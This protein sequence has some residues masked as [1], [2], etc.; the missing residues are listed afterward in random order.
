MKKIQKLLAIVF[1][2]LLAFS[3]VI[4]PQAEEAAEP[5]EP[6]K[7]TKAIQLAI[8]F[9]DGTE[10]TKKAAYVRLWDSNMMYAPATLGDFA[11]NVVIAGSDWYVQY[12][13]AMSDAITGFGGL[14]VAGGSNWQYVGAPTADRTDGIGQW[15]TAKMSLE[16]MG[17]SSSWSQKIADFLLCFET[18]QAVD[19]NRTYYMYYKNMTIRNGAGEVVYRLFGDDITSKQMSTLYSVWSESNA[20][21]TPSV[22]TD[23]YTDSLYADK[24]IQMKIDFTNGDAG[25]N[26]AVQLQLYGECL[27]NAP[28][29]LG[30]R[31]ETDTENCFIQGSDWSLKYDYAISDS[32]VGLGNIQVQAR[33]NWNL[34]GDP[35]ADHTAGTGVWQTEIASLEGLGCTSSW[36]QGLYTVALSAVT[37]AAVDTTKSYYAW[38]KNIEIID[39]N[40]NV[41]YTL[42]DDTVNNREISATWQTWGAP[43]NCEVELSVVRDPFDT[44]RAVANTTKALEAKIRFTNGE[45][46]V[47]K[48]ATQALW[49]TYLVGL[50]DKIEANRYCYRTNLTNV[51]M[52]IEGM[53]WTL[54]YEYMIS[55]PIVGLGTAMTQDGDVWAVCGD[56][57][58]DHTDGVGVWQKEVVSLYD[59][60]A[61]PT[62]V[63]PLYAVGLTVN[64]TAA[65]DTDRDYYAYYKNIVIKDGNGDIQYVLFHDD[66][67]Q[68]ELYVLYWNN[69]SNATMDL[70]V[71]NLPNKITKA[72]TENGSFN[73]RALASNEAVVEV[74]AKPAYGYKVGSVTVGDL[75]VTKAAR[76][77]YTFVMPAADVE[78]AVNFVNA[79][80]GD[81]DEDENINGSDLAKLMQIVLGK[82]NDYDAFV[83]NV[84]DSDEVINL[85]DI[86][87]LKKSIAE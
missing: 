8:K 24:A 44:R 59:M 51:T 55:D 65:V 69:P 17:C 78:V 70:S 36:G 21:A 57:A 28:E 16:G 80:A 27:R 18:T 84:C 12:D 41:V 83:A 20:S 45:E 71:V 74:A 49:G 14:Y 30:F 31:G 38:Y 64:T 61:D 9:T 60:Y 67:T 81:F 23:P 50:I 54:E 53:D 82:D 47:A 19:T 34:A 3:F 42:F 75:E 4:V 52:P 46:G 77:A 62:W 73:V 25:V 15:Q 56:S 6:A 48:Y 40:G 10:G 37:T 22:V 7:D 11:S 87:R 68:E 63:R 13:Y 79:I 43:S 33:S 26:K 58:A 85:L 1:A 86:V 2:V 32:V 66:I 39:G 5:G 72:E 76:N 35:S 29:R